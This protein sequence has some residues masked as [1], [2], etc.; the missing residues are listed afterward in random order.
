VEDL[1]R[2][3]PPERAA[4]AREHDVDETVR[5]AFAD[6]A[7]G[8]LAGL[9]DGSISRYGIRPSEYREWASRFRL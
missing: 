1:A 9:H 3:G 6:T 2:S 7:L 8:L 4:F 5:E